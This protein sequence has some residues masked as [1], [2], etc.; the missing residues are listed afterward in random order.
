MKRRNCSVI[1]LFAVVTL[2][3]FAGCARQGGSPHNNESEKVKSACRDLTQKFGEALVKEDFE[4]AYGM[5]SGK[6]QENVSEDG[7]K[8]QYEEG[9][10]GLKKLLPSFGKPSKV[11]CDSGVLP[12][13]EED[14][15]NTYDI[16]IDLPKDSW[17]GWTFAQLLDGN[18][19]GFEA[20]L[21]IVEE[22]GQFKV[23]SVEFGLMD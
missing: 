2:L 23:G 14:A 19:N 7:L 6:F 5:T 8:T 1:A 16:K 11:T 4:A 15:K 9:L 18:D 13:S 12:S 3:V 10:A 17:R 21:L 20:R 22:G